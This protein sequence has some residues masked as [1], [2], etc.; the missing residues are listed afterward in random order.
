MDRIEY[1]QLNPDCKRGYRPVQRGLDCSVVGCDN[2]CVSNDMCPKHNMAHYRATVKSAREYTK[3]YNRRY[4][5]PDVNKVC[6]NC[7]R[8][9][10]TARTGQYLCSEC[11]GSKAGA[12]EAQKRHRAKRRKQLFPRATSGDF[13]K[14]EEIGVEL[15]DL[16]EEN[17]RIID[18]Y[19]LD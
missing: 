2:K 4:K 15:K 8:L 6:R 9:Y 3:R 10:V 1:R 17:K 16:E 11:S 18:K 5:R 19:N 13:I 12:Y 14:L 7:G